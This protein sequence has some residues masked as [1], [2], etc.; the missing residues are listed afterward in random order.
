MSLIPTTHREV[1]ACDILNDDAAS[2]SY[3]ICP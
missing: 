1:A 2:L 3:E